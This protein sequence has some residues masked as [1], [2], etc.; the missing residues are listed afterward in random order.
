R[1]YPRELHIA[2]EAKALLVKSDAPRALDFLG[3]SGCSE[4]DPL[5]ERTA[6]Q[7]IYQLGAGCVAVFTEQGEVAR[8]YWSY[9]PSTTALTRASASEF[10]R[11]FRTKFEH[12]VSEQMV[13][14]APVGAYLSGGVDSA[15]VVSCMSRF[16][17][18]GIRTYTT[19]LEGG[20]EDE[21]CARFCA[22][23]FG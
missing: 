10:V 9:A 3:Y 11:A 12:S 15:A 2:S 21:I 7:G 1:R 18:G 17:S 23:R 14:D 6:F 16:S 4:V 22:A 5:W 8:R 13:S 19:A 20:G